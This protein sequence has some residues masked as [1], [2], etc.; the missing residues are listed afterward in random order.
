[1][2]EDNVRSKLVTDKVVLETKNISKSFGS[3]KALVDVDF[4]LYKGE[5]HA[6]MGPNGSGK[7]T[8]ANTLMGNPKYK[9]LNGK[10][11][12]S[13]QD[14]G[15]LSVDQRAR[16]GIFLALQN[17]YEVPGLSI[18]EFLHS[19]YNAI[20]MGT[21]KELDLKGFNQL[22]QE[23][24]K[25]LKIK[26]EFVERFLNV[27]F[28]GGEKKLAEILQLAVLQ[29]KFVILDEID[30]GLDVDALKLVCD[31]INKIKV[32][33]K[34]MSLLIITHYP[35]ILKYLEPDFVHVMKEG[36]IIRSGNKEIAQEIEN[37]GYE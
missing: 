33:F 6:I 12:F 10:I 5:I 35:R 4:K 34:D 22:I 23:K 18:K 20:Y 9:I 11:I 15:K 24:M 37:N 16:L 17:P 2:T 3:V 36:K 27:G 25:M 19:A 1:M 8:L 21:K 14:L 28:S 31:S 13:G 30:S 32:N 29:P 26:Q 7:S